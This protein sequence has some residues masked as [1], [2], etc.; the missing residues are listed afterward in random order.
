MLTV[1]SFDEDPVPLV[2]L[3]KTYVAAAPTPPELLVARQAHERSSETTRIA[4]DIGRRAPL[5]WFPG[6]A[7]RIAFLLLLRATQRSICLRERARLKQALLYTRLR[8]ICL[9]IGDRLTRAGHLHDR[10]DVFFLTVEELDELISGSAMFPESA[11]EL[12]ALRRRAHTELGA[13]AP[14]DSLTLPRGEY[15]PPPSRRRGDAGARRDTSVARRGATLEGAGAC[16]GITTATAAILN[17]VTEAARLSEGDVL[18]TRQTDP[19]WAAVF[20]LISGLVLERGGMLSHGAIIA[21][22]FGI[23]SVVGVRDATAR[24]PNGATVRVDGDRGSVCV[25]GE[26]RG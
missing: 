18:V 22:E 4:E 1:P 9:A 19:G 13:V 24:I 8:H 16:G 6:W 25:V 7:Q 15:L 21:R 5:P 2:D 26:A 3:L 23:P 10:D 11:A 12:V 14:P 20:P 17:D